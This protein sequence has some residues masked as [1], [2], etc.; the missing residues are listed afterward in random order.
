MRSSP[1]LEIERLRAGYGEVQILR[2][3]SLKVE[4]GEMVTLVGSNGAGKSTLLN[5]ICGIVRPT[6]GRVRLDGTDITGWPSEAIVAEGITQVPE[7]RRLFPQMT[8]Y[9]NLLIGA[10]R[11]RDGQGIQ[12]DIEAMYDL[13][14]ILKERQR[15][16]AGSMSGGEQQMCAI[17]RGLMARPRILILDE[18][19][20]GLA[21]IMLD[22]LVDGLR[23]VHAEGTTVFVVEQDVATAFDLATTGYVLVNGSVVLAGPTHELRTNPHVKKAYLGL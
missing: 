21:P 12:R 14:P 8:V 9:E 10:Y 16:R 6:A 20:L 1:V 5:T 22:V 15:Q 2:D 7:G 23:R 13:F 19:S 11:R 3:V 4:A 17:A 18:L